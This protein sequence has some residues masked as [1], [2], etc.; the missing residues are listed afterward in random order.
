VTIPARSIPAEGRFIPPHTDGDREFN[1][2][3]PNVY[4]LA[5]LIGVGTGRLYVRL[6]MRATETTSDWTEA[7]GYSPYYLIY[8]APAGQCV[9]SV[10]RGIHDE[11]RYRDTD[12]DVDTMTGQIVGS[13]VRSYSFVGDIV[14]EEAGTRTGMAIGTYSFT[15][16]VRAC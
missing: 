16:D 11:V 15:A 13:F 6:W 9:R 4:A 8:I 12:H 14:G 10:S 5:T 7:E 1:G 2:H 3:G